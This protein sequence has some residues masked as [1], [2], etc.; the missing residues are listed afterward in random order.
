VT[1]TS[2]DKDDGTYY[3]WDDLPLPSFF[4]QLPAHNQELIRRARRGNRDAKHSVWDRK[5]GEWVKYEKAKSMGLVGSVMK[6]RHLMNVDAGEGDGEDEDEGDEEDEDEERD[7]DEDM[8]DGG[9]VSAVPKKRKVAIPG[10]DR[11]FE[12][13]R[14]VAVP[15]DK[16][17]KI[18]EPKYLADRRPGMSSLYMNAEVLKQASGY[19]AP[20]TVP[21]YSGIDLGDGS[22]LGS[23][24]GAGQAPGEPTPVRRNM[25][26]KRKK[27]KLGGPGR[28]K[29]VPV[30][31]QQNATNIENKEGDGEQ[32]PTQDDDVKK[33][34][35][36]QDEADGDE[37]SGDDSEGEG[38]EEGEV[39]EEVP[40]LEQAAVPQPDL[41]EAMEGVTTVPPEVVPADTQEEPKEPAQDIV[42]DAAPQAAEPE[43]QAGET[44]LLGGLEAALEKQEE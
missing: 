36:G 23:A 29:A 17:D 14:W 41:G 13:R 33:E 26:P 22:G 3:P 12:V 31:V 42:P 39:A 21:A 35:E 1:K 44:D 27:K 19:G 15:A 11:I 16:A 38:S 7:G 24:I 20:V 40:G 30:E 28:R 25:P 32:R 5:S 8:L 43:Q 4:D 37:G 18:P 6:S 34:G 9:V 2:I 10:E